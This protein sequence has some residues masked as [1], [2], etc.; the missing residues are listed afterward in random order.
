MQFRYHYDCF[1]KKLKNRNAI[2]KASI[3]GLDWLQWDDQEK[4]RAKIEGIFSVL[5]GI[6]LNNCLGT[7]D[8]P[9]NEEDAPKA[10]GVKLEYAK[11]NRGKCTLCSA[12][13]EKVVAFV[14]ANI[15]LL[16]I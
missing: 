9:T 2:N 4:I 15:E 16:D 14:C 12:N 7:D 6:I 10:T 1:W 8:E 11:T 5:Y 3:H 13:I